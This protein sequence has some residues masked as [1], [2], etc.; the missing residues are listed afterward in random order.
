LTSQHHSQQVA[1]APKE[2]TT[3]LYLNRH[4]PVVQVFSPPPY[5]PL[6]QLSIHLSLLHGRKQHHPLLLLQKQLA[7]ERQQQLDVTCVLLLLL[8]LLLL[9]R[10]QVR[11]T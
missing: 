4:Q 5:P 10:C 3:A 1:A 2:N 9:N 7:H 8:L 6:K 11:W